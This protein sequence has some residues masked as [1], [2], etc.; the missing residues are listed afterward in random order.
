MKSLVFGCFRWRTDD[1]EERRDVLLRW[2]LPGPTLDE[3]PCPRRDLFA[4]PPDLVGRGLGGG[5]EDRRPTLGRPRD[6]DPVE[7]ERMEVNVK[8]QYPLIPCR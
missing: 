8:Q 5:H 1:L 7:R 4:E 2:F 6:V 3:S